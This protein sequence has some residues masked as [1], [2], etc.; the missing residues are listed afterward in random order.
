VL[1]RE[2][3]DRPVP[4]KQGRPQRR[5]PSMPLQFRTHHRHCRAARPVHP[6]GVPGAV[7]AVDPEGGVPALREPGQPDRAHVV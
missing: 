1:D 4:G 5:V 6:Q 2:R 7:G 3:L